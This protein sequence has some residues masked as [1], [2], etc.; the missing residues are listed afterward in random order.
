MIHEVWTIELG[1]AVG[2]FRLGSSVA[3]VLHVLK[4]TA[5]KGDVVPANEDGMFNIFSPLQGRMPVRPFEIVYD[6]AEPYKNNIIIQSTDDGMRV[7]ELVSL[8][9]VRFAN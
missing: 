3:E 8:A 5:W 2:P 7:R 4:V 6:A 1:A 9:C